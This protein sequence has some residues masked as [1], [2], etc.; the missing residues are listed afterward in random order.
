MS[1]GS[2]DSK[3]LAR[4]IDFMHNRISLFDVRLVSNFSRLSFLERADLRTIF[5]GSLTLYKPNNAVVGFCPERE[6]KMGSGQLTVP[7]RSL[8]TTTPVSP[9]RCV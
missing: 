6:E 1:T 9:D 2:S 8:S 7:R 4:Y 5:D 3:L